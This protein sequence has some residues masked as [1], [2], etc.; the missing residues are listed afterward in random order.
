MIK[1]TLAALSS[2][3]RRDAAK[4]SLFVSDELPDPPAG[5]DPLGW[6][7][8]QGHFRPDVPARHRREERTLE[9][10]AVQWRDGPG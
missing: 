9:N 5:V 8:A 1:T 2:L 4:S 10:S 3:F 6:R 7:I